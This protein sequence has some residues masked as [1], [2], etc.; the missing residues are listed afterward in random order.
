MS[1]LNAEATKL[2]ATQCICC[3]RALADS[4]S[5]E[6][7]MGPHCRAKYGVADDISPEVQKEANC[8]IHKAALDITSV[9][10]RLEIANQMEALGFGHFAGIVRKRF[11]KPAVTL[12]LIDDHWLL[13]K[14]ADYGD[15]VA[16]GS[17]VK[18]TFEPKARRPEWQEKNGSKRFQGWAI[19][20]SPANKRRLFDLLKDCFA[21][22]TALGPKGSFQL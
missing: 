2:T 17:C 1:Y 8:L 10:E 3:G 15:S 5:V 20:A 6:T 22:Q 11:L 14:V 7:G 16:F 18:S 4:V 12:T 9:E 21:D 19:F 13:V